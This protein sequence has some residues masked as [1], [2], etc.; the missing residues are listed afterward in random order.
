M[1]VAMAPSVTPTRTRVRIHGRRGIHSWCCIDRI[2]F[3]HY[4]G[5]RDYDWPPNDD[6]LGS[7]RSRF[8]YNDVG[9]GSVLVSV[10]FTL[11]GGTTGIGS[12][13]TFFPLFGSLFVALSSNAEIPLLGS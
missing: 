6:C 4:S 8:L 11:I 9:R 1:K 2:F 5:R 13:C 3:H 10:S 12:G 7:N